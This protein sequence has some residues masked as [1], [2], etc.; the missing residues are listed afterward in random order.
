MAIKFD[1]KC[2][3][4]IFLFLLWTCSIHATSRTLEE[5]LSL[6]QRH[7]Q[8][9]AH[10]ARSYKNDVEKAQRFEIFKQNLQFIES[11]NNEGTRSY[12]LGLNRFADL[13]HEEFRTTLLNVDSLLYH[14]NL[15]P[16][17][18][19][20][21]NSNDV[22]DSL[23]WR[24]KGA[25]TQVKDQANCSACWAFAVV[26]AVEGINEIKTGKLVSLSEQQL[27]DC[28]QLNRFGCDGGVI[29]EAFQSVEDMGGLS[30]ESNYPYEASE[31]TC[32]SQGSPAATITGFEQVEKS[33]SALLQAVSSQPVSAGITIGGKE[34]QLYSSGVFDGDCGSGSYHAVTVVG[35]GAT[36]DGQKYW[37]VKNSW[38]TGWGEKGYMKMARDTDEEGG[39]CGIA[40]DAAYPT[41]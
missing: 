40:N 39:L 10:H 7:E 37:V 2:I 34:F 36:N 33:E 1:P 12:K 3:L 16:A 21:G 17:G 8:W 32:N 13:T 24:E 22:P 11:F 18:N 31:G 25:V 20:N 15:F 6:L 35:Y 29:T 30:S 23:D 27:L 28:D 41:A 38:G 5:P 19:G 4:A 9:M 14:L 26:A